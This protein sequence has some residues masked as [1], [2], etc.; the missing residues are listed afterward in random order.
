M[1]R[2]VLTNC[3][4]WLGLLAI[5]LVCAWFLLRL[6]GSRFQPRRLWQLHRDQAGSVQSL[7]FVLTLPFFVMI[8]LFI[9]QV[10]QLMIGTIVVHYAAFATAR[11]AAVWIPADMEFPEGHNC[12]SFYYPDPEARDQVVPM[13]DPED[14][15][16][17][18]TDGGVTF[19][20]EPGSDKY[21]KISSAAVL[22][23]MP[24]CP[25]RD[26]GL[27]LGAWGSEGSDV[28]KRVYGAMVPKS[29]SNSRVPRRLENK[30]AYA[31]KATEV[32]IRFFHK[33]SEPPLTTYGIS[34]DLNQFSFNELGWQDQI[35][36]TVRHD[37]ALLPGPGRLLARL[38][39]RDDGSP[40]RV[41]ERIERV[42]G[43]YVYPLDA[44]ITMCNEGETPVIP[45]EH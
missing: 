15:S 44:S 25:S 28:L 26:L 18:P 12:I 8:V 19:I 3:L 14:P 16:Y 10:S 1:G 34:H 5:S 2:A 23:C 41:S 32:E 20:I 7:S 35:T 31:L 27:D 30:L 29:Q 43:V 6:S 13:L 38:V 36:V 37:L 17:G 33:N 24:I 22:A 4:P 11:S 21:N 42:E 9:V 45:Y 39:K 40:D